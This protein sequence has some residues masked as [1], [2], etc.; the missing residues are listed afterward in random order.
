MRSSKEG[1]DAPPSSLSKTG[2]AKGK[3]KATDNGIDLDHVVGV[4]DME[5]I[6]D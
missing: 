5:G 4:T 3:A 2:S 1:K 6:E